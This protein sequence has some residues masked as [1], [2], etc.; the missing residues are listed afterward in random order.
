[1]PGV[2]G[3]ASHSLPPTCL[4]FWYQHVVE[5]FEL[6]MLELQNLKERQADG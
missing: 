3:A 1:M 5:C 6:A 2:G 4:R